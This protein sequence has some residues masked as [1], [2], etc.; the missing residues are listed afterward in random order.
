AGTSVY[1]PNDFEV[2]PEWG[3]KERGGLN[4]NLEYRP[5]A[6]TQFYFRPSLSKTGNPET[7][8]EVIYQPTTSPSAI[9]LT[10]PQSGTFNSGNRTERRA[11]RYRTNRDL[12]NYATGMKKVIGS[13]TI[14]P[15]LTYSH[16]KESNPYTTDREF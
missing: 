13:F 1:L 5:D 6:D 8:F 10:S 14:E 9:T 11:F 15:M 3:Y 12:E 4:L 16:A 2:K 7:R